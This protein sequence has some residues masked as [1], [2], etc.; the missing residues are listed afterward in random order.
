MLTDRFETL[1]C[2]ERHDLAAGLALAGP[3]VIEE[4]S[5]SIVIGPADRARIDAD[6]NLIIDLGKKA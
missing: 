2:Y 6:G 5:T 4:A 3:A 1:P